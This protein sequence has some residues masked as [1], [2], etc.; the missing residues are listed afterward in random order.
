MTVTHTSVEDAEAAVAGRRDQS[1]GFTPH[2]AAA[3]WVNPKTCS[4]STIQLPLPRESHAVVLHAAK[5]LTCCRK[6][7]LTVSP[8]LSF[9]SSF[10]AQE[11]S[12]RQEQNYIAN[13]GGFIR[14]G[15]REFLENV[16]FLTL[17]HLSSYITTK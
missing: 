9:S 3:H 14:T 12:P 16:I 1:T 5:T 17:Y 7:M 15:K 11:E 2:L 10:R 6:P 4:T 13:L 8:C